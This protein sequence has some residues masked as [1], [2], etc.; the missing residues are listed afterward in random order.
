MHHYIDL[1]DVASD[2]SLPLGKKDVFITEKLAKLFDLK[3][4]DSWSITSPE[5]E[6]I[7]PK[8]TKIVKNYYLHYVY[9]GEEVYTQLMGKSADYDRD[10]LQVNN[11]THQDSEKVLGFEGVSNLHTRDLDIAKM[12]DMTKQLDNLI[13]VMIIAAILLGLVVLYNLAYITI[14]ERKQEIAVMRVMGYRQKQVT[15]YI[16]REILLL[17]LL[18]IGIGSITGNFLH[19]LVMEQVELDF[20][21]FPQIDRVKVFNES[22]V[23][24][25]VIASLLVVLMHGKIKQ[26]NTVESLK[27]K[28]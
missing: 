18:S 21:F 9:L 24:L 10:F 6:I 17:G 5:G 2:K 13:G 12:E 27:V 19:R 16:F 15:R 28:D 25:L 26:I 22:G 23:T 20:L 11:W 7:S 8:V 4:G 1:R 14:L 3:I